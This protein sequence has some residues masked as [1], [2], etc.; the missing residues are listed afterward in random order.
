[1]MTSRDASPLGGI[2]VAHRRTGAG[3][4]MMMRLQFLRSPTMSD[5]GP[6]PRNSHLSW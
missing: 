3:R 6:T 1:L 2:C 4:Y 5:Q